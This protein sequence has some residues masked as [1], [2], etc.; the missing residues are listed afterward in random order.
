MDGPH[1]SSKALGISRDGKVAVGA[2]QVVD[3]IE[4]LSDRHRLGHLHRRRGGA[5]LQRA[6]GPGKHRERGGLRGLGQGRLD[7]DGNPVDCDYDKV[8]PENSSSVDN[9]VWCGSQPVGTLTD[10]DGL[11]R[12]GVALRV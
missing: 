6:A 3:F 5:A 8:D 2:T 7:G 9:L 4:G 12:R 10:G 11:L 1:D